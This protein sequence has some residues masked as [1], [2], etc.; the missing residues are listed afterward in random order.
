MYFLFDLDDTLYDLMEPFQKT[1]DALL[2]NRTQAS[3]EQLFMAS[4]RY[5]DEAFYRWAQGLLSKKEEFAYRIRKTYADVGLELSEDEIQTFEDKYR[6]YQ[7]DIHMAEEIIYLLEDLKEHEIPMAV[8]SNGK[9]VSQWEKIHTLG[10][11]NWIP[12]DRIFISEDL[13][14]PKPDIRPFQ[15]VCDKLNL[16]SET[17]WFVG[18]T[19]EVDIVGSANAGWH[20]IW[21]NHR[22]KAIPEGGILPDYEV[23][24]P[25]KLRETIKKIIGI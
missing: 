9:H 18:D 5:S 12:K 1:H 20:N 24:T 11:T 3:C 8:L 22:K 10:I 21:F 15:V 19:Y 6:L 2:S 7:T 4:R 14:A 25:A 16:D 17:T 13:P 23:T